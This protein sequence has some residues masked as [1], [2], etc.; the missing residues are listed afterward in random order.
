MPKLIQ[1]FNV[2]IGWSTILQ[3][4][5]SQTMYYSWIKFLAKLWM[6]SLIAEF[7]QGQQEPH[8]IIGLAQPVTQEV[9]ESEQNRLSCMYG[10][11]IER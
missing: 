7:G 5:L 6:E 8:K 2:W 9:Q 1:L 11:P 3:Q 10:R 4:E